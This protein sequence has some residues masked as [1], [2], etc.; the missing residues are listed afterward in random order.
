MTGALAMDTLADAEELQPQPLPRLS[1]D[2]QLAVA[3]ASDAGFDAG[4]FGATPVSATSSPSSTAQWIQWTPVADWA[5]LLP[6]PV[7]P[8]TPPMRMHVLS[9]W[10]S[11]QLIYADASAARVVCELALDF[12]DHGGYLGRNYRAMRV[13]SQR[14]LT[15]AIQHAVEY[16]VGPLSVFGTH[17]HPRHTSQPKSSTT[18]SCPSRLAPP[19]H[20]PLSR[21]IP[22]SSSRPGA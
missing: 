6:G 12:L 19:A 7:A 5:A 3:M 1:R 14:K 20:R 13:H 4:L 11:R 8:W 9:V 21:P 15:R 16:S 2:Y 10:R 22:C 17:A 18:S